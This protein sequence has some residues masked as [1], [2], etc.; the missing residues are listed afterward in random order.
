[1][2]LS[3]GFLDKL[4]SNESFIKNIRRKVTKEYLDG[5]LDDT[6]INTY[7]EF[8][9]YDKISCSSIMFKKI[10]FEYGGRTIE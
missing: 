2:N 1:M 9:S 7:F 5:C 4:R 6:I 8:F 10:Y 3:K